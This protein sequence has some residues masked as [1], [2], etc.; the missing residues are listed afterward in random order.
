MINNQSNEK[1]SITGTLQS[2]QTLRLIP[3]VYRRSG[4][5]RCEMFIQF[6]FSS[7]KFVAVTRQKL[8]DIYRE[9]ELIKIAH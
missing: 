3:C 8:S 5:F 1:L 6:N 2:I 7:T 9:H 4:Y